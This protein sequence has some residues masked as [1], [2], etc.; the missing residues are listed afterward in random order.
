MLDP[1]FD[2]TELKAIHAAAA[3]VRL[4]VMVHAWGGDA[5]TQALE[6]GAASIEHAVLISDEQCRIA[7]G[8]GALGIEVRED[9]VA[10]RE[11]LTQTLHLP[12]FLA[13]HAERAVSRALGGAISGRNLRRYCTAGPGGRRARVGPPDLYQPT[14]QVGLGKEGVWRCGGQ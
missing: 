10:L 6:F 11:L 13:C 4:P 5:L 2:R 1:I 14:R 12:T 3:H 9:N 7:A 8:Q